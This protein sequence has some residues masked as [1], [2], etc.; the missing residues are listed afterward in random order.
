VVC[1]LIPVLAAALALPAFGQGMPT[2]EL[3]PE[4]VRAFD[5]YMRDRESQMMN[6]RIRGGK[7][8]WADE[9]SDR[10]DRIKSGEVMVAP[11]RDKG[12]TEIKGGMLND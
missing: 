11:G 5:L 3:R 1:L 6:Q 7:F 8:L 12:M 10:H 4:A 2:V 9:A